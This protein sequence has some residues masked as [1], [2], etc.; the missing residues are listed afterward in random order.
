L[1]YC[2]D[3]IKYRGGYLRQIGIYPS[4]AQQSGAWITG[5][6]LEVDVPQPLEFELDPLVPGE[7]P[8]FFKTGNIPLMR[9]DLVLR[10]QEL[11]VDNIDAY[12]ATIRDPQTGQAWTDYKAVNIV[13]VV[14]AADLSQSKFVA[15]DPPIIDVLFD[16][17]VID[18]SKVHGLLLFRLAQNLSAV[19]A[20]ERIRRAIASDRGRFPHM[21]FIKPEDWAG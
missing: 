3:C 10:L 2:M 19:V 17:L 8:V 14:A 9:E 6:R 11:G 12:S 7:M 16:K 5:E 4:F 18:E 15:A 13:G 1:Y 21:V 20:D